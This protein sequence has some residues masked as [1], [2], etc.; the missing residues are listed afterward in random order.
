MEKK[1]IVLSDDQVIKILFSKIRYSLE[2]LPNNTDPGFRVGV[3]E[4]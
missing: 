2:H 1:I 3:M 4:Y